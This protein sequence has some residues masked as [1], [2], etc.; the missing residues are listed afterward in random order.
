M[1]VCISLA[2]LPSPS[3]GAEAPVEVSNSP[4]QCSMGPSPAV[5]PGLNEDSNDAKVLT[6][7]LVTYVHY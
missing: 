1:T 6:F 3:S 4:T 2:T 5:S 7:L